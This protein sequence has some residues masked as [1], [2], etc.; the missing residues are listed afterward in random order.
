[1][2]LRG[3][4]KNQSEKLYENYME[5]FVNRD[6][7]RINPADAQKC[8]LNGVK[9]YFERQISTRNMHKEIL[10]YEYSGELILHFE[11]MREDDGKLPKIAAINPILGSVARFKIYSVMDVGRIL[12]A[13]RPDLLQNF[14]E[15]SFKYSNSYHVDVKN[16]DWQKLRMHRVEEVFDKDNIEGLVALAKKDLK[17][18][19]ENSHGGL[20]G[21][22]NTKAS[23]LSFKVMIYAKLYC[24][25]NGVVK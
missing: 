2:D 5:D 17:R 8:I 7:K 23:V 21:N 13:V 20:F 12:A 6:S 22:D 1:M 14:D 11:M 19:F 24:D 15:I 16:S 4:F 3:S 10:G 25:E 9:E 18:A